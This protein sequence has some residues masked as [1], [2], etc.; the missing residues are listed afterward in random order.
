[1]TNNTS[2]WLQL[3]WPREVRSQDLESAWRLLGALA[4]NGFAIES[5]GNCGLVTHRIR[6]SAER[7]DIITRELESAIP[8]LSILKDE[9]TVYQAVELDR[10]LSLRLNT[11]RRPLRTN[12]YSNTSRA[13]LTA[14]SA[15]TSEELI[16]I[17]WTIGQRIGP[18]AT[19]NQMIDRNESWTLSTLESLVSEPRPIDRELHKALQEKRREATWHAIGYI[20][21]RAKTQSRGEKLLR[22]VLEALRSLEAPGVHFRARSVSPKKLMSTSAPWRWPLRLNALEM[23]ALSTWPVDSIARQPVSVLTS[24]IIPPSRRVSTTGR[25]VAHSNRPGDPRPL[26]LSVSS[27]LRHLHVLGPTGT[28]K[29]TALLNLITQDLQA[30]RGVVVIES[31]G[32]LIRDVLATMP[33]KRLDDVVVLDP[34]DDEFPVGINPLTL[35]GRSPDF[36]A[37]QLL[38]TMHSLYRA[39][40]GPRTHD[41]LGSALLTLA[42]APGSTLCVLPVLLTDQAFRRQFIGH[43]NDPI[44]LGP[45]WAQFDSWSDAE[46]TAATA[47]VLNKIRPMLMNPRLRAI[48]GQQ[49]PPFH[50]EDVF[51]KRRVLLV[52]L[53]KGSIG[54]EASALLGSLVVAGLWQA[55]LERTALA[56]QRRHPVFIYVDEFQDYLHL[57]TDLSDGLGQARGLGVGLTLAHQHLHQLDPSMRAAVLANARSRICFQLPLDDAKAFAPPGSVPTADEFAGLGAFECYAQLM[58]DDMVQP[59]CSGRTMPPPRELRNENIVRD[60]SRR[61]YGTPRSLVDAGIASLIESRSTRRSTGDLT[62]RRRPEEKP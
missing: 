50:L 59:W 23:A 31:K 18:A 30:G 48:L 7:Q 57:P 5:I 38:S 52:N 26:G 44:A 1:V 11:R 16:L 58:A 39:H 20:A 55:A 21:V 14:L 32:D 62:P 49:D 6:V 56:P 43:V 37:D 24:R 35:K 36:V 15:A 40:W 61:K 28:G 10:A 27:S 13:L 34:T 45:F 29:S 2:T 3:R 42:Q 25:V 47:P 8:G 41:I 33:E 51:K 19:P 12:D 4:N 53:A 17:R 60:R 46:R 9:E 54:P 22:H